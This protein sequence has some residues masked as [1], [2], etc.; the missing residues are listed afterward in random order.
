MTGLAAPPTQ[1]LSG[2]HMNDAPFFP[3][4]PSP[5]P[6]GDAAADSASIQVPVLG[7]GG[8][9]LVKCGI[10]EAAATLAAHA[11][12]AL[13][14]ATGSARVVFSDDGSRV[15]SALA[16]RDLLPHSWAIVADGAV[17]AKFAPARSARGAAASRTIP[18][19]TLALGHGGAKGAD[20]SALLD[21][22][23]SRLRAMRDGIAIAAPGEGADAVDGSD[24]ASAGR[25]GAA[26]AVGLP[27]AEEAAADSEASV[28]RRRAVRFPE[29]VQLVRDAMATGG[30]ADAHPSLPGAREHLADQSGTETEGFTD[31]DLAN[32]VASARGP[33]D[34]RL[35]GSERGLIR[36]ARALAAELERAGEVVRVRHSADSA[37]RDTLVLIRPEDSQGMAAALDVDGTLVREEVE[38]K[39][40]ELARLLERVER[41]DATGRSISA[42][43]RKQSRTIAVTAGVLMVAQYAAIFHQIYSVSWDVMEPLCYFLAQTYAIGAY[44]YFLATRAEPDNAGI[45]GWVVQRRRAAMHKDLAFQ[46]W[47]D[48]QAFDAKRAELVRRV[49]SIRDEVAVLLARLGFSADDLDQLSAASLAAPLAAVALETGPAEHS[50]H[51]QPPRP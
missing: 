12:E 33:R 36:V 6:R 40:E 16:V 45:F 31:A 49:A 26:S 18:A 17:I 8:V 34:A 48:V 13:G 46:P 23:R 35:R 38:A 15:P 4:L 29:F 47:Q 10:N 11:D 27:S 30:Y 19:M 14:L 1:L 41:M 21:A 43:A 20:E 32:S 2:V 7:N 51:E 42:A 39:A 9:E 50:V 5:P 3:L 25:A 28:P 22:V 37:V 44:A 24:P